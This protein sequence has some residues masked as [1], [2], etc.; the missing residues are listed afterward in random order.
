M[1]GAKSN[2]KGE[3]RITLNPGDEFELLK[4]VSES[5]LECVARVVGA[6]TEALGKHG[7]PEKL[8][9]LLLVKMAH[10][11]RQ[12]PRRKL[13]SIALEV[14]GEA[15]PH[16]PS[17]PAFA[18]LVTKLERDFKQRR[19]TWTTLSA[20][21]DAPT[22]DE[23]ARDAKRKRPQREY[24]ALARIVPL[25]PTAIDAYDWLLAEAEARGSETA[26]SVRRIGRERSEPLLDLALARPQRTSFVT[27]ADGVLKIP[28][29]LFELVEAE[30]QGFRDELPRATRKRRAVGLVRAV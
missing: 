11:K 6:L 30:L 1:S 26:R 20:K 8:H 5:G 23:I 12:Q 4:W 16:Q 18:S 7:Q 2:A 13:H 24:R 25:L 21:T 28:R 10:L 19:H 27:G 3:W 22:A 15:R 17:P 29:S 14:A 9:S